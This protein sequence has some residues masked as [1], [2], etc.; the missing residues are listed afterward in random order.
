LHPETLEY[1]ERVREAYG[2]PLIVTA[3]EAKA[4]ETLVAAKG[5]FSFYI[6]GHEECC[7]IRKVEPLGRALKNFRAWVTGRRRDQN[8]ETRKALE[9]VESD[10]GFQG[11]DGA[12]IKWNPLVGWTSQD[13]WA[14]L[15]AE[16]VP[17][18]PLHERGFRSIGCA[19][20]TRPVAPDE[21]ERAGR[22]WWEQHKECGLHLGKRA[23]KP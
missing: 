14:H 20:C 4:V 9:V 3:P 8:A 2:F 19:P 18:N 10:P 13:V 7:R 17:Q 16:N 22:W 21:D 11:K 15:K 6:D 5:L 12:L 1:V 23:K